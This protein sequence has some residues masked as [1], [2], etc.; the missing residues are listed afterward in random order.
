MAVTAMA[1][2]LDRCLGLRD[3]WLASPRFQRWAA[4]FPV[5]RPIARR[6][7]R[8]LFDLCAGFVYS[9]VLLACVRLRVCDILAEGPQ[10]VFALAERLGLSP[11]STVRLLRAAASLR[12]IEQRGGGR[13]GLGPL[14]A[15][16]VGNP[17]VEAM[18]EHHALLYGDLCD[19]VA[20]LRENRRDTRLS[21]Y[22]PYAAA[23]G[24]AALAE[25][26]VSAYTALMSATQPLIAA[27]VLDAYPLARHRCLLD[28]GGGDGS[29]LAAAAVR[30][31]ALRLMLFDLP[32]VVARA[33]TRFEREGL[34]G[35]A[36]A[37]GGDVLSDPL[38]MGAD[39]VSLVRVVHDHDDDGA[40]AILRAVRR[41][42]P[43]HG[44]LLLAEPMSATPGAEP[45]GDAYFGFYLLAMGRGRPRTADELEEL[46]RAA[47]FGH[48]RLVSTR[49]PLLTRLIVAQ[50]AASRLEGKRV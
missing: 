25:E 11:D 35:R 16:L 8:A 5:T 47:G 33:R 32:P 4:A 34:A 23:D 30:A 21:R 1:A 24:P 17:G 14:G 15:A 22:W 7:A 50:P 36:T 10:S 45:I 44:T 31:P 41:A 12:L 26:R 48:T 38:P 27:E 28:V 46:L 37:V 42:L 9:Q 18:V 2:W 43:A 39:I 49:M 13:F 29:F 40:S 6:R 20:L 3:R 19:P